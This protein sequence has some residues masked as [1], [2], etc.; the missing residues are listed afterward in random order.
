MAT[1]LP[2]RLVAN[3]LTS[4]VVLVELLE[5][6]TA[7]SFEKRKFKGFVFFYLISMNII[8]NTFL[9]DTK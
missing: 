4:L 1:L 8:N 3:A 7:V 2:N 9:S 5:L 6:V